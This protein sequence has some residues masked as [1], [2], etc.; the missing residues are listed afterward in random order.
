YSRPHCPAK[1][2]SNTSRGEYIRELAKDA[3]ADGVIFLYLKFCDPHAFDYPYI[4]EM[5]EK[6]GIRTHL[7]EV[8]QTLASSGQLRTKIQAFVETL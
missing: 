3:N 6:A 2:L 7:V 8:E 5:L 4:K 1:H